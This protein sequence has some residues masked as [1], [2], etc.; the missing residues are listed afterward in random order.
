[1]AKKVYERIVTVT[2][3]EE[4]DRLDMM[5][6]TQEVTRCKDCIHFKLCAYYTP[7]RCRCDYDDAVKHNYD[8]CSWAERREK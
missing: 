5:Y 6:A 8:Y 1:M 3:K 4:A 7:K 2:T